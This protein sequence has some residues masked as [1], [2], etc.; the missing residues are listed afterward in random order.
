[1][2]EKRQNKFFS[3]RTRLF[4]QVGF[5]MLIA[6]AV[7]LILNNFLLPEIYTLNEKRDMVRV[8]KSIDGLSYEQEDY[9][10]S[11]GAYEKANNFSI[12]I[13]LSDGTPI[14]YGTNELFSVEGKVTISQYKEESDGSFFE[15]LTNEQSKSQY[16]V[17]GAHLSMG[18]EIEIYS[19]KDAVDAN[20]TLAALITS[21]T[22]IVALL[23]AVVFIYF[24]TGKFTKPLIK[25]SS[26][27]KNM[28]SL[29]FSQHCD[30]QSN[31][32]IGLLSSSINEMSDSLNNALKDLSE[33]NKKLEE[34]IEMEKTLEKIRK[35]FISNVSHELK[36]PISIIRGYSEGAS[37]LLDSGDTKSAKEYFG[38]I[39]N[40]TEKMNALVLQLLELSMYESGSVSVQS[41]RF[42]IR[43]MISN[44]EKTV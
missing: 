26:V 11:I 16:L 23:I 14:Y 18:G 34:D 38:I 15:I 24:F 10:Q 19:Q 20:A 29:D 44:S 9:T 40:E 36:T 22:S 43:S 37:M 4:L 12:D 7:I 17:Y 30:I 32:E 41:E 2:T 3:I 13:Y 39:V 33:K 27:T 35:D 21:A 31:D 25:M 5:I 6:I 28:A 42:D 1:M 8:Y